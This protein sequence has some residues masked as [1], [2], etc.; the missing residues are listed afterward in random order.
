M[1][2]CAA[3]KTGVPNNETFVPG[4]MSSLWFNQ[5]SQMQCDTLFH[6]AHRAGLTTCA[7]RWPLTAGGFD[8][9]D[10]LVPEVLSEDEQAEPDPEKRFRAACSP[11]LFEEI[12][13]PHLPLLEG[14]R[15]PS[16]DHFSTACAC[17]ILRKYQPNLLMTHPGMVDAARHQ[18]GLFGKPVDEALWLT[19]EW[20]G[21][22]MQAANDAGIAPHTS[23]CIVSDH[24]QLDIRL[25]IALNVFLRDRGWITTDSE[26]RV[27]QWEAWAHSAGLSAQIYVKNR[28][29]EPAVYQA[30]QEMAQEGLYG[31]SEVLTADECLQRY[32]LA[33]GFSFVV[34]TDGFTSF[35]SDG[36]RPAVRPLDI[37]DY[38]YGRASHGHM[39]EKGPQP[40]MLVSG[41][42]F[43]RHVTLET[44]SILDE[45][46][47]FAAAL[48]LSLEQA[49]GRV[50]KELLAQ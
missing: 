12:I 21:Q 39:P 28:R 48:G 16:D 13:K 34:E 32:G 46:P 50:L 10:Y 3:A 45:A 26:G 1:S 6:A 42:A 41:P 27:T 20:I 17:D 22:L 4:Q 31:F 8:V 5:L 29:N 7:C 37:E 25:C 9:I 33:G 15:H 38:R 47:T 24:W 43:A 23:W 19:D 30:L 2:G 35:H 18:N 40:P 36:Q 14:P 11:G 49:D 44:A